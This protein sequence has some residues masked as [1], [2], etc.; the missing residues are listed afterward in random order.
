MKF[1][2]KYTN[3]AYIVRPTS[4]VYY[5]EMG[6]SQLKPGL[7][8]KFQGPQRIF[9]SVKTQEMLGWSDA[10]REAVEDHLLQHRDWGLG[11][12]LAP[13][14][15]LPEGKQAIVRIKEPVQIRRCGQLEVLDGDIRQCAEMAS[16]GREFCAKHDPD[17]PKITQSTVGGSG[18]VG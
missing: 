2:S 16:V 11:L 7:A 14:E 8:A 18:K 4:R 3:A 17:A 6:I 9:D 15:E 1:Q 5:P 12:Y 13:G 10:E